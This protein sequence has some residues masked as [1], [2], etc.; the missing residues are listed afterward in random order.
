[1][2]GVGFAIKTALVD[3]L[4]EL[5]FGT[6]D[7]LMS[8]RLPLQGG[9]YA[10]LIS[11][12]APTMTHLEDDILLF[13]SN[14]RQLLSGVNKDDKILLMGDFNARVG[15]DHEIWKC[16]GKQG[17]GKQNSNGLHLVQLCTE[18]NLIIG[19]TV[20]RQKNKYKGTWMHPRSKHWHMI[21]FI[22]TRKRDLQDI[23]VVKVMRGAECWTDHRLVRAKLKL[24][25]RTKFHRKAITA[26]KLDVAK[27]QSEEFCTSLVH[28]INSLEPLNPENMWEDFKVK[29]YNAAKDVIGIKRKKHQDWFDE[30]DAEIQHLLKEKQQLLNKT[31][32]P[33]RT[34]VEKDKGEEALRK[35]KAEIQRRLRHIQSE[36]WEEKAQ[37]LQE[38]SNQRDSKSMYQLLKEVYGPKESSYAP[39]KS[40]DGKKIL[41]E[42]KEIQER[43][44]EHYS[45][46]LNRPTDVDESVLDEIQ[47]CPVKFSL[48][49]PPVQE[50]VNKAIAQM[51]N[52]KSPG[53]DGIPAEV[54]KYGGDKLKLMVFEVISHV[55]DANTPQDW[56]DAI[57]ESLFKKGEKSDCGNFRGISL[58]SIVG[59]VFA[60]LLLT[61]LISGVAND[62]LPESQCGFRAQRGASDMIF[63][64]RQIQEKCI[65]QNL[66][67][68]QCFIDLT[69]AFDTVN[70]VMLWKVLKKFGCPD[71][72][73]NLI[74]SLHDDMKAMVNFNGSLSEPFPVEGGVKQG[75]NLAPTLLPCTLLLY[76]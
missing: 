4:E 48:D 74:K 47:Q 50:E 55:W 9:R 68:Y 13:C 20:Y 70:R 1:M 52:G 45:D 10:T 37:A 8:L 57:L 6:T 5:P 12:Y 64:A 7:R 23:N 71:K 61:R 76:S 63:S 33:N 75:D 31:L 39:L 2:S 14:L 18:F 11:V 51:N 53:M 62:V 32:L 17:F 41:R 34:A 42:P 49:D 22:I 3:K 46:L 35:M 26:Q 59:K 65:E 69:K 30:N 73:V 56:R 40:K 66:N 27:L 24:K 16:L 29:I 28:S 54:L 21:D 36:W 15:T 60:R 72:F 38:A 43:W 19:N 67:L 25:I 58:L 44:R